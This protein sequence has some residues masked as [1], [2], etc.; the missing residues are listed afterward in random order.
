MRVTT[1]ILVPL[2]PEEWNQV[3]KSGSFLITLDR[4]LCAGDTLH[5]VAAPAAVADACTPVAAC[6]SAE[7]T[8]QGT[9]T[10]SRKAQHLL[11]ER[12]R[13]ACVR[14]GLTQVEMCRR[15]K[16]APSTLS[17][18]VNGKTRLLK[19]RTQQILQALGVA[20][21][22]LVSMD[23]KEA[24][25]PASGPT[26]IQRLS[27]SAARTLAKRVNEVCEASEETYVDIAK[28]IGMHVSHLSLY[29]RGAVSKIQVQGQR[30]LQK[31][32]VKYDDLA[33]VPPSAYLFKS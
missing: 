30:A 4:D 26:Q 19:S 12:V 29:R 14:E 8:L 33:T 13:E 31:L 6:E 32:G 15:A 3:Q 2:D 28:R 17:K 7:P 5:V 9:I 21:R 11:A 1:P 20:Y 23:M 27:K 24:A 25:K 22:D 10:L 16:C 18:L